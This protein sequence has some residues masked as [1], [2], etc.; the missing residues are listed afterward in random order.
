MSEIYR[1]T[2]GK[3]V[4]IQIPGALVSAVR[5]ERDGEVVSTAVSTPTPIPYKITRLDGPF[6]VVW[7]YTVEGETYTRIDEHNVVT[8]LFSKTDLT[9]SDEQFEA[10]T[11]AKVVTLERYIREIV[12]SYTGQSFGYREG[13][14]V[15]YGN[16]DTVLNSP[17]RILS[18][19]NVN[20]GLRPVNS[21]FSLE[22]IGRNVNGVN[23]KIPAEEEAA[24][25]GVIERPYNLTGTFT[26]NVAYQIEGTFGWKSIP[27]DV[28]TAALLLAEEFSCDE[29]LWRDR[30]IKSV[31][32]A[33]WRFDYS[34]QA[35]SGTGSLAADQ[36]LAKYV[37]T[38][39][40]VV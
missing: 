18:L 13:K 35:F 29:S 1:D 24:F 17:A 36:L 32:A 22:A 34:E 2:T 8:P 3:A 38:R 23:I 40:V 21:G 25:G 27:E 4:D 39:M 31:R 16:G 26:N 11:D 10:L 6:T 7:T 20:S 15:V 19:A 37:V 9:A 5:F 30:Y 12:E 28:K 33:D 14:V